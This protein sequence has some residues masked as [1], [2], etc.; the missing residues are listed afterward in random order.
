M[1]K[2]SDKL[3]DAFHSTIVKVAFEDKV[4]TGFWVASGTIVTC[5]HVV[6]SSQGK[7][8]KINILWKDQQFTA[9]VVNFFDDEDIALI[10]CNSDFPLRHPIAILNDQ[11][12]IDDEVYSFGFSEEYSN[13]EPITCKVEGTSKL[14]KLIK[15]KSGQVVP[16]FSGAPILN[17][18]TGGVCGVIRRTRD[19]LSDLGGRAVPASIVLSAFPSISD[20]QSE[21]QK[22]EAAWTNALTAKQNMLL[23]IKFHVSSTLERVAEIY[24]L[25]NYDVERDLTIENQKVDLKLVRRLADIEIQR[26]IFLHDA[27]RGIEQIDSCAIKL[28]AI[29]KHN[30]QISGTIICPNAMD[31]EFI[32]R[33]NSHDIKVTTLAEL[34]SQLFDSSGYI[35]KIIRETEG[36]PRYSLDLFIEPFIGDTLSSASEQARTFI[37]SWLENP[38]ERQLTVL[39]DVGIGKTFLSRVIAYEAALKYRENPGL[40]RLPIRIDLRNA[41]RQFTLEGLFLSHFSNNEL[42]ELSFDLFRHALRSGRVLVIFDGFDEMSAKV[43]PKITARNFQELARI[44][45]GNAK[46]V[47][48]CRTHYF[49]SRSDE[50]EVVY[51]EDSSYGSESAR[52]L[53]W[54]LISR[55]GFQICYLREFNISQVTAYVNKVKK[56]KAPAAIKKIKSIYNLEEL[57]QR[58]M[59]LEMIVKSIGKIDTKNISAAMLYQVFTD[60]W[61]HRDKWRDILTP[62]EKCEFLESLACLLTIRGEESIHYSVLAE[63]VKGGVAA[64]ISDPKHLLEID[65]DVRTSTFLTRDDNGN[66]GFTHKSYRE[67][68]HARSIRTAILSCDYAP[69]SKRRLSPEEIGFTVD[70][71]NMNTAGADHILIDIESKLTTAYDQYISENLLLILIAMKRGPAWERPEITETVELPDELQLQNAILNQL[72]LHNIRMN[73]ANLE[74]ADLSE[75]S[76]IHSFLIG[77]NS[78]GTSY[79]SCELSFS[80]FDGA[81]LSE[82]N[83]QNANLSKCSLKGA[84]LQNCTFR[85]TTVADVEIAGADLTGS[86]YNG[87][88]LSEAVIPNVPGDIKL[89]DYIS[90]RGDIRS[91]L[92]IMLEDPK[93]ILKIRT[94]LAR[95]VKSYASLISTDDLMQDT[96]LRLLTRP[97]AIEFENEQ[98]IFRYVHG[99]ARN[100]VID[101]TRQK[102]RRGTREEPFEGEEEYEVPAPDDVEL[103]AN[104]TEWLMRAMVDLSEIDRQILE[105][106]LEGNTLTEISEKLGI[107]NNSIRSRWIR[108]A[109]KISMYKS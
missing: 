78:Y 82:A 1:T 3:I 25:L 80:H 37:S 57:C 28:H 40:A 93:F 106:R 44:V 98:H 60:A 56:S 24:S 79:S 12:A 49:K 47:L 62:E 8:E 109:D 99:L 63:F 54:D 86:N 29:N 2:I 11:Y 102:Q 10:E 76:L 4:G 18:R 103:D 87:V 5:A 32:V 100:L 69:L 17:R 20:S 31:N 107:S 72:D 83:F 30:P 74:G 41:D 45:E 75:S 85:D 64:K 51:G 59:L 36:D 48:T 108:I 105:K 35:N 38:E 39:G 13:G 71:L 52:E 50:Q 77:A 16:G 90:N 84:T 19:K 101:Y 92:Q 88:L 27:E 66:Y 67:F 58:P 68:F 14:P 22:T 23:G 26:V 61:I 81:N 91:D 97:P 55:R 33:A 65:S 34:E 21:V 89:L 6:S 7:K 53:Y 94:I 9:S 70:L 15:L 96:L 46:V 73:K 104:Y 43:T 95:I 42:G